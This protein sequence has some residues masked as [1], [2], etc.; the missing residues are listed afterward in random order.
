MVLRDDKTHS[1][2]LENVVSGKV[3]RLHPRAAHAKITFGSLKGETYIIHVPNHV[4]EVMNLHPGK[5][6]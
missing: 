3:L 1:Q 5:F 4:V 6:V 2:D